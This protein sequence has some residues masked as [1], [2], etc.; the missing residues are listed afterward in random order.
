MITLKKYMKMLLL[1]SGEDTTLQILKE[2]AKKHR[3]L[4]ID[5]MKKVIRQLEKK[6]ADSIY[7]K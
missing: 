2:K 1:Y 3:G 4:S 7:R 6:G 5:D